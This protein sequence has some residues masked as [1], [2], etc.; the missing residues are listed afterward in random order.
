MVWVFIEKM[1]RT[2]LSFL[3]SIVGR[4]LTDGIFEGI[5]QFVKFGLIGVTNTLVN[6]IVYL[7]SLWGFDRINPVFKYNYLLAQ[8]MGFFISVLWSYYWNN[9]LVFKEKE[10]EKRSAIKT[11]IKTYISYSF[12]GLFLNMVI[13][14]VCVDLLGVATYIAPVVTIFIAVPVNFIINKFWAYKS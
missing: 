1:A 9:R 14:Y 8:A 6:Y 3:F 4:E 7:I 2:I 13:L 12:T 5:M 10:G 11:L